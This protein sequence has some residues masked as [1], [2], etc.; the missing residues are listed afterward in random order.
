MSKRQW[1][2]K[3][4]SK[5]PSSDVSMQDLEEIIQGA[6]EFPPPEYPLDPDA[7]LPSIEKGIGL[8]PKGAEVK[9]SSLPFYTN[10]GDHHPGVRFPNPVDVRNRNTFERGESVALS[11]DPFETR[12]LMNG[13]RISESWG[14]FEVERPPFYD[15]D[16]MP[17]EEMECILKTHFP[18]INLYPELRQPPGSTCLFGRHWGYLLL[19]LYDAEGLLAAEQRL[20][21]DHVISLLQWQLLDLVDLVFLLDWPAEHDKHPTPD[22][23]WRKLKGTH[24]FIVLPFHCPDHWAVAIYDRRLKKISV[25]D[26]HPNLESRKSNFEAM[27]DVT[28]SY[29]KN[30]LSKEETDGPPPSAMQLNLTAQLSSTNC[31]WHVANFVAFFF[32]ENRGR[33]DWI[34]KDWTT[35]NLARSTPPGRPLEESILCMW[36]FAIRSEMNGT[37]EQVRWPTNRPVVTLDK[38]RDL[39]K[40]EGRLVSQQELTQKEI[41]NVPPEKPLPNREPTEFMIKNISQRFGKIDLKRPIDHRMSRCQTLGFEVIKEFGGLSMVDT[42]EKVRAKSAALHADQVTIPVF[43][44]AWSLPPNRDTGARGGSGTPAA[45]GLREDAIVMHNEAAHKYVDTSRA[46][47]WVPMPAILP[48]HVSWANTVKMVLEKEKRATKE[49]QEVAREARRSRRNAGKDA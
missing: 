39:K 45:T 11:Q 14:N 1:C 42:V 12:V 10:F 46:Y 21:S 5:G 8:D 44:G 48:G 18:G 33:S 4:K 40:T 23:K 24:R 27:K 38:M 3:G 35:S 16:Q 22:L 49:E 34:V 41:R 6:S 13:L 9:L 20:R 32:R 7:P 43:D 25:A 17:L 28:L 29:L 26:T 2:G 37:G 36:M 15:A 31:G 19:S 30:G 47:E